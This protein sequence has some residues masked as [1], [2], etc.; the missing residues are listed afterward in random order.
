[1]HVITCIVLPEKSQTFARFFPSFC[2]KLGEGVKIAPA[3]YAY[4]HYYV[5]RGNIIFT[6]NTFVPVT[7]FNGSSVVSN[8][9][10]VGVALNLD[11]R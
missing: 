6:V 1:M 5:L 3:A 8:E 4:G 2:P 10:L 9:Q 7:C 11:P